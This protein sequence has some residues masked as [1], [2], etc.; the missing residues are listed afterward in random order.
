M[1]H[2]SIMW[3]VSVTI[4][5]TNQKGISHMTDHKVHTVTD[6]YFF[7]G[8]KSMETRKKYNNLVSWKIS[9]TFIGSIPLRSIFLHFKDILLIMYTAKH[10]Y[11][12]HILIMLCLCV[13]RII[14]SLYLGNSINI[15]A[16]PEKQKYTF[17][18]E[19]RKKNNNIPPI[20]MFQREIEWAVNSRKS[21]MNKYWQQHTK[22]KE[23]PRIENVLA[24]LLT[25]AQIE[26]FFIYTFCW[27]SCVFICVAR[28]S[29]PT[30]LYV[31]PFFFFVVGWML[32]HQQHIYP[33]IPTEKYRRDQ[34]TSFSY[35]SYR[36]LLFFHLL[37]MSAYKI[38]SSKK[39]IEHRARHDRHNTSHI[40]LVYIIH[41]HIHIQ[42]YI[43]RV[44]EKKRYFR[45]NQEN[46]KDYIFFPCR[47][48]KDDRKSLE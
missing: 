8:S 1:H 44:R 28:M 26:W 7:L 14:I 6:A 4:S 36:Y 47:T 2:W 15:F 3:L 25:S 18:S 11:A 37:F 35:M 13:L 17:F 20:D 23:I 41:T 38:F 10:V 40:F 24:L 33:I 46:R 5:Y 16:D 9:I 39:H 48:Y 29:F 21:N 31:F 22:K 19:H 32:A 27:Y 12:C 43:Q 34:H 42:T 45:K 30:L